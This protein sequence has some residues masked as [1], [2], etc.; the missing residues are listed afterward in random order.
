M[1]LSISDFLSLTF[2]APGM[3]DRAQFEKWAMKF[4]NDSKGSV[5][6]SGI[7]PDGVTKLLYCPKCNKISM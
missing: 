1:R 7:T 3:L 5:M 6:S 2:G 4:K